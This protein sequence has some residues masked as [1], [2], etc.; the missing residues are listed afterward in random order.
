[1]GAAATG[2]VSVNTARK[3]GKRYSWGAERPGVIEKRV[4]LRMD[5]IDAE[6]AKIREEGERA[7]ARRLAAKQAEKKKLADQKVLVA[8]HR[9]ALKEG[10]RAF[11]VTNS[12][13]VPKGS[14]TEEQ[15]AEFMAA[16][17]GLSEKEARVLLSMRTCESEQ[18][19]VSRPKTVSPQET[20][21]AVPL[22]STEPPSVVEQRAKPVEAPKVDP[23]EKPKPAT[24]HI[25]AA[26]TFSANA[27]EAERDWSDFDPETWEEGQ[28]YPEHLYRAVQNQDRDYYLVPNT[29]MD[30]VVEPVVTP[31]IQALRDRCREIEKAQEELFEK[32]GR[33]RML[34]TDEVIAEA[35]RLDQEVTD[36]EIELRYAL[37][38]Q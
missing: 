6:M 36:V 11:R 29:E 1:M 10:R 35:R 31:E 5:Q 18:S 26:V 20:N 14:F 3:D 37:A 28:P 9:K 38:A 13:V 19:D 33:N 27:G 2:S 8:E 32:F 24:V 12:F 30:E 34:W 25:E 21:A 22:A 23:I 15:L 16:N 17:P 7:I 4:Q